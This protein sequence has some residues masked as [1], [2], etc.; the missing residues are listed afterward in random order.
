MYHLGLD[1][2]CADLAMVVLGAAA[3]M[4]CDGTVG[5]QRLRDLGGRGRRIDRRAVTHPVD[6]LSRAGGGDLIPHGRRADE[7]RRTLRAT[8]GQLPEDRSFVIEVRNHGDRAEMIVAD[9]FPGRQAVLV[10]PVDG[11]SPW[12]AR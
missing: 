3:L 6:G 9:M 7:R 4:G 8:S 2:W 1:R 12:E 10:D 5:A 11:G